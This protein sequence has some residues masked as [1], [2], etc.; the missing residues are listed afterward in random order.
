LGLAVLAESQQVAVLLRLVVK[1]LT[2]F[3]QP[4]LLK[5][6]VVAVKTGV[7][8]QVVLEVVLQENL[9]ADLAELVLLVKD[10][11]VGTM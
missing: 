3:F 11:R 9:V 10:L 1:D 2:L 6:A 8:T 7:E 4:L 5:V